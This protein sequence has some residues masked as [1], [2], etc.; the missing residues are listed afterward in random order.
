MCK[1]IAKNASSTKE[2]FDKPILNPLTPRSNIDLGFYKNALDFVFANNEVRNIAVSGAY[3][4]GKSSI[5]ATYEKETK[6]KFLHISLAHFTPP[7]DQEETLNENED[8]AKIIETSKIS[9]LEWKI[10]NQLVHQIDPSTIPQTLFRVKKNTSK[11]GLILVSLLVI[12]F[13]S[14]LLY[15]LLFN[16]WTNI[17]DRLHLEFLRGFLGFTKFADFRLLTFFISVILAG[18]GLFKL[19]VLQRDRRVIKKLDVKGAEI[20]MFTDSNESYF[21]KYLNEVLYLFENVEQNAIIFED[22]DR[23]DN[24]MIFERLREVNTLINYSRKIDK[25]P[26]RFFYLLRDD[27]FINKDRLKFFD[28]IIPVIPVVDGS[29]SYDKFIEV[30]LNSG[31]LRHFDSVFLQ[32]FSLYIDEMRL[33]L[34]ICN[35]YNVYYHQIGE[36]GT[37]INSNK[38]MAMIACKNLF[39]YDFAELQ[40]GR[41]FIFT[42]LYSK[43]NLIHAE[44]E[45]IM[46]EIAAYK[47]KIERAKNEHF[48]SEQEVDKAFQQELQETE[49]LINRY[50]NNYS[51]DYQLTNARQRLDEIKQKIKERKENIKNR[52]E[53]NTVELSKNVLKL[54]KQILELRSRRIKDLLSREN[55][56]KIFTSIEYT[57]PLG[58]VDKFEK[59][60]ENSYFPLLVFLIRNGYIDE[61]YKDYM[62]YFYPNSLSTRDA[63]FCRSITDQKAKPLDY[64]IDN[65]GMIV[66]RLPLEYFK[67]IEI[68]NYSLLNYLLTNNMQSGQLS[69]IIEQL[70]D[71]KPFDII[72]GYFTNGREIEKFVTIVN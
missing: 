56:E 25:P 42:L 12:I 69:L 33:L 51:Y 37:E 49:Q 38:L 17:Y 52:I 19:L 68:L 1:Q 22:I 66:N 32:G 41:G 70:V 9:V 72:C 14:L 63:A 23:F 46:N 8:A 6:N 50:R 59:V 64:S 60:K 47:E 4:S 2:N 26:V 58:K 11:I 36:S 35:E 29:N 34:N 24:N 43:D 48:Q 62:T 55:C 16:R 30:L 54:E 10:L 13:L 71:N 27:I 57:N 3:G 18:L 21:D 53:E 39:P 67:Q 65:P 15:T 5:I 28:L 20:E 40:F 7:N 45:H 61:T 31:I 44:Q